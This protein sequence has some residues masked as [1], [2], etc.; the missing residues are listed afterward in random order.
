M[1]GERTGDI[2]VDSF[3]EL[4]ARKSF[5][6][7]WTD[8]FLK[9]MEMD[10]TVSD[11]GTMKDL[12][13]YLFGSSEVV[14]LFMAWIMGL[15]EDSYPYARYLGRA[16]QYVNFIRDISEDL[17]LGRLYFPGRNLKDLTLKAWSTGR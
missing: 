17:Q 8:A 12:D 3:S 6:R 10:I 15:D 5:R 7:E 4:S 11:Y 9:S 16:M 1:S 14:G 13:E 2:V